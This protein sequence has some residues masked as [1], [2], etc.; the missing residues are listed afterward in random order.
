GGLISTNDPFVELDK[1]YA[2]IGRQSPFPRS[3][4]EAV[5]AAADAV[6]AA[7]EN[8]TSASDAGVGQVNT[9]IDTPRDARVA[10]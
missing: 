9:I 4:A 6:N 5:M 1:R 2:A 7:G 8:L 3:A 10:D